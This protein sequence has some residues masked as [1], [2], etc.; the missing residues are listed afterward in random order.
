[1]T[2][3]D[4]RPIL[5]PCHA[6]IVSPCHGQRVREFGRDIR[7]AIVTKT[8]SAHGSVGSDG[9]RVSPARRNGHRVS[10]VERD[11]HL[12]PIVQP[13]GNHIGSQAHSQSNRRAQER[14]ESIA[15]SDRV[16]TRVGEIHFG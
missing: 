10:Q 4:N 15:H 9:Q 6:V 14:A 13:P 16:F 7:L 12:A 11:V 5:F 8:P 1:M 3:G 2:P